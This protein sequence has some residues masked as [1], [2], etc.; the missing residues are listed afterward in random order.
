M[1]NWWVKE[2]DALYGDTVFHR[3]SRRG[4]LRSVIHIPRRPAAG[5]GLNR[6]IKERGRSV[7]ELSAVTDGR[8]WTDDAGLKDGRGTVRGTDVL[9]YGR[10]DNLTDD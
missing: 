8:T 2:S 5:R 4:G 6:E 1:V 10:T 9:T 3:V 7:D